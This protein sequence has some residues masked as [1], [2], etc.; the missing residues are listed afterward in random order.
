MLPWNNQLHR[1]SFTDSFRHSAPFRCPIVRK[2]TADS[3]SRMTLWWTKRDKVS[4][5]GGK[6]PPGWNVSQLSACPTAFSWCSLYVFHS[7][8]SNILSRSLHSSFST[9][10]ISFL[11]PLLPDQFMS[12]LCKCTD[13]SVIK[14]TKRPLNQSF[15]R[16]ITHGSRESYSELPD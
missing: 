4:S 14:R 3:P 10:R 1:F 15:I 11:S 7:R 12:L 5:S 9:T 13:D 6:C 8:H 2:D 16:I